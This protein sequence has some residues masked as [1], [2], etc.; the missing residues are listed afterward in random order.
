MMTME[1]VIKMCISDNGLNIYLKRNLTV[2]LQGFSLGFNAWAKFQQK[3]RVTQRSTL[4]N[5]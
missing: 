2:E 5:S 1:S 4:A 3:V